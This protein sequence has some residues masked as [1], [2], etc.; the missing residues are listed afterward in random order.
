[1]NPFFMSPEKRKYIILV[2]DGMGDYP[3]EALD[4]KTPLEAAYTPNM[5]AVASQG[6]MGWV[7]TIPSACESG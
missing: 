6:I 2:G 7:Q 3:Q 5:D 1:M 4:G